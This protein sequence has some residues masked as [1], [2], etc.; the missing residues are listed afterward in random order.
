MKNDKNDKFKFVAKYS[1]ATFEMVAVIFIGVFG[2]IKVDDWLNSKPLFIV[3]F[4]LLSVAIGI[5]LFVKGI[6]KK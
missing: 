6:D 1:S 3:I 2:G 4:S 5:Y